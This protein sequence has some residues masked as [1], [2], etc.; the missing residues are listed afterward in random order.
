MYD[1]IVVGAGPAGNIAAHDLARRGHSVAVFDWRR[2]VGDKLCTGIIG[3]ECAR[4]YPPDEQ[5]IYREARAATIVSPAGKRYRISKQQPQAFI[6]NRVAYVDALARRAIH[7]GAEYRLGPRVTAIDLSDKGV[8]VATDG[9]GGPRR[10]RSQLLVIASGFGSP[11]VGMAGLR[12]GKARDYMVGAQAEVVIEGLEDTEVHLGE[13]IAPG[14]FGWVVP[15]SDE[16]ALVGMVSRRRANGSGAEFPPFLRLN[17]NVRAVIKEARRWGIPLKPIPRT[18]GDRVLVAG[19]AAGLAKPTTGGGIYYALLSGEM[20][21]ETASEAL[22]AGDFRARQLRRYER[23]WK[24]VIG[25]ELRLG[26]YARMLYER[27]GDAQIEGLLNGFA[28]PDVQDELVQSRDFS[29]DWHSST[30]QKAMQ[31]DRLRPLLGSFG[32]VVA[33]ILSRLARVQIV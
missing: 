32:P 15:L 7:A 2:K 18:Y 14:S 1:V 29:F 31:N 26:Y 25:R 16:R 10:H 27:L 24:Q 6:I 33:P 3:A 8:S 23:R 20:A 11:L 12:S 22:A 9:E 17:G 5:H 28:S 13:E 19:D 30:I 21:A 4:R